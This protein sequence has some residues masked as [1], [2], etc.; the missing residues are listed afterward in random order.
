MSVTKLKKTD[1]TN[2]NVLVKIMI[3]N[4]QIKKL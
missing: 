3:Q 4:L 1:N 2:V